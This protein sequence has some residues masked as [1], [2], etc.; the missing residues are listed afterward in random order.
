MGI[1][2]AV[3]VFSGIATIGNLVMFFLQ[4]R[5]GL[6]SAKKDARRTQLNEFKESASQLAIHVWKDMGRIAWGNADSKIDLEEDDVVSFE[7]QS[8][9]NVDIVTFR[10]LMDSFSSDDELL[11]QA[12]KFQ[13]RYN[14]VVEMTRLAPLDGTEEDA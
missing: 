3:A 7:L 2:L 13:D 6:V 8:E 12:K 10:T 1:A 11:V 5:R 4:Y 9:V 14:F